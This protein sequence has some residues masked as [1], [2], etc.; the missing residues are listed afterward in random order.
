MDGN[1]RAGCVDGRLRRWVHVGCDD[2][3]S[4][5]WDGGVEVSRESGERRVA[6]GAGGS[7]VRF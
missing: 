6:D 2:V 4:W 7:E 1:P 5:G 3:G